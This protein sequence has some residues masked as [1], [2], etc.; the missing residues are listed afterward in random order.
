MATFPATK[1]VIKLTK[2]STST[3]DDFL[4]QT[5]QKKKKIHDNFNL[6][7]N[8]SFLADSK[9]NWETSR[10]N[11]GRSNDSNRIKIDQ[12]KGVA[13]DNFISY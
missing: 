6:S 13:S 2:I 1:D 5:D 9:V 12:P 11:C 7:L 10:G 4:F 3:S 8:L